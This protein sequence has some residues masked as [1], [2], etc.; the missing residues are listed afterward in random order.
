M[1]ERWRFEY[2]FPDQKATI[3]NALLVASIGFPGWLDQISWLFGHG[4]LPPEYLWLK[5]LGPWMVLD[6][7]SA[8]AQSLQNT[9]GPA[10]CW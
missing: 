9:A 3:L 7:F 8:G 4:Y 1:Q 6:L 5:R 2:G 10:R